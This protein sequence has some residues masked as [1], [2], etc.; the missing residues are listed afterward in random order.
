MNLP[1]SNFRQLACAVALATVTANAQTEPAKAPAPAAPAPIEFKVPTTQGA[2]PQKAPDG[3]TTVMPSPFGAGREA[4]PKY[5][6][7]VLTEEEFHSFIAFQQQVLDRPDCKELMAKIVDLRKQMLQLQTQLAGVRQKAL[8]D[9]PQMKAIGDKMQAAMFA[10]GPM[11]GMRPPGAPIQ[12]APNVVPPPGA[13]VPTPPAQ[14][15]PKN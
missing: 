1:N 3:S 11:P 14:S 8:A 4:L 13:P 9:N 10:H 2:A 12:M 5:L 6:E 7:G 15:P